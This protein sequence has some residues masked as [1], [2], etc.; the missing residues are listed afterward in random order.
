MYLLKLGLLFSLL[1]SLV[2]CANTNPDDFDT[3]DLWQDYCATGGYQADQQT[4][5]TVNNW[6]SEA[7]TAGHRGTR[8]DDVMEP[9]PNQAPPRGC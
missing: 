5:V 1:L 4:G 2:A 9:D 7:T 6:D 8:T 3:E